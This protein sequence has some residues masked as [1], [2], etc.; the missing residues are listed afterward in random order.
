M[1]T[2]AAVALFTGVVIYAVLGGADYGAGF[3]D[4]T[5][6]GA[7]RGRRPRHLVDESLA[8]V[9]EANHVWLIFCLVMLWTAF[10]VAFAAIM[11]TLYV[12]LGLAALGIVVRG[13]GFAFRKVMVRTD[14]QRVTGA[15]FAVSSVLVPFFL[16]TVAGG[17]A[18]GRVPQSGN[19]D[20]V[21][22][23]LNPTS[24]LGGVLAVLACAYTAAVFLTAEARRR[25]DPELETWFRRRSLATAA[26]V[27]VVAL[28]GIAVLHAD[29]PTLFEGLLTRGLVP[30]VV[31]GVCGLSALVLLRRG[32]PRLLQALA[33]VAVAAIVAGWGVAQYPDLLGTHTTIAAAAAPAP[34]LWALVIVAAA[35]LV[36]VVPSMALLF[37]L[38]QRGRLDSSH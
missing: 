4:L 26:A 14:Q 3:W 24:V 29:S 1:S 10:P 27:G 22:G 8:P 13:A 20:P 12:P 38:S 25:A 5:A 7:R 19:G 16:G 18:S 15:A 2:F 32:A 36:I 21:A 33:V 6:G 17:I 31:S 34:T 37:V 30:V 35:A 11:T 9:W 28:A 23:W